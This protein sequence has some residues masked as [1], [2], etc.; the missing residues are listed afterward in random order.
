[1]LTLVE[2]HYLNQPQIGHRM[3][4][5]ALAIITRSGS[6]PRQLAQWHDTLASVYGTENKIDKAMEHDQIALAMR[7]KIYG[8]QHVMVAISLNN[9]GLTHSFRRDFKS[10]LN[11]YIRSKKIF[12]KAL[13]PHHPNVGMSLN[14]IGNTYYQMN[15]TDK[16]IETLQKAL[17]LWEK[18]LGPEHPTLGSTLN[19]LG[20][21]M[22]AQKQYEK[23]KTYL[24][25]VQMI[26]E[27]ALGPNHA[28]LGMVHN[29]LGELY[30]RMEQ[31]DQAVSHFRQAITIRERALGKD[32]PLLVYSLVGLGDALNQKKKHQRIAALMER[33]LSICAKRTCEVGQY[34]IARYFLAKA[35]WRSG[36][37]ERRRRALALAQRAHDDLARVQNAEAMRKQIANW[38]AHIDTQGQRKKRGHKI[39]E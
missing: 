31:I 23:A 36:K 22:V 14:N 1:M 8:H 6:N 34:A 32:H 29:T 18:A 3:S 27:K 12:E 19:S 7:E 30:L 5:S 25:R 2:G 15:E 24:K 10:A 17:S 33:A 4:R 20:L 21:L 39:G 35:L 28:D 11:H 13:G 16:S 38:L 26:Y 37:T 9:L